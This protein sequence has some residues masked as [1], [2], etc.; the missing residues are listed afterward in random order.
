MGLE[1]VKE[2]ILSNAKQ[3][4]D[5]VVSAAKS[6][7]AKITGDANRKLEELKEKSAMDSKKQMDSIKRQEMA[8]AELESKKVVMESRKQ[9]MLKLFDDVRDSIARM[10][11][12]KREALLKK[13]LDKTKQ[14]FEI[15]T[16]Y[17]NKKDVKSFKGFNV[18]N[19]EIIGGFIAEN[20]DKTV[21]VDNTFE[22]ML[23]SIKD[24]EMQMI[25]K[26]L[27]G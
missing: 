19:I 17:C 23:D 14:E 24:E 7:A 20:A 12:K 18:Q 15:A 4:A 9:I 1:T 3:K 11:D 22:T 21:R 8:A 16:I 5:S 26:T 27:F 6:E 2:E 10:D 25:N 13:L